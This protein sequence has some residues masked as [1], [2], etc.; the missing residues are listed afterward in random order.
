[1]ETTARLLRTVD[2][3]QYCGFSKSTLEKLRCTGTGPVFIRRG[4]AVFYD[5]KNLDEWLAAL[6]RYRSTSDPDQEAA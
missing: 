2:A 3:A 5:V 4:R 6:P 1:M